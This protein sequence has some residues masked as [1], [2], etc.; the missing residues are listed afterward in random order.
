MS[1]PRILFAL[2]SLAILAGCAGPVL[3][4]SGKAKQHNGDYLPAHN[5]RLVIDGKE[6]GRFKHHDIQ[7]LD[8]PTLMYVDTD[9]DGDGIER[10]LPGRTNYQAITLKRGFVNDASLLDWYKRIGGGGDC[11]D[12]RCARKSGSIIYLDREGQEVR[13]INFFEAWPIRYEA[14]PYNARSSTHIVEEIEFVVEKIER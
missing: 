10:K 2:G 7:G 12:T 9:S 3:E 6:V 5:L 11:D 14:P 13:R 8:A 1:F 4:L